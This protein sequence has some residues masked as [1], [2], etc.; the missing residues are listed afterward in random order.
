MEIGFQ[1]AIL[2]DQTL[3][4]VL[5]FAAQEGFDCIEAVCWPRQ[6][7]DQRRYAGVTHIDVSDFSDEDAREVNELCR[8]YGVALS[9]LGYYPNPLTPD[10][11]ERRVYV[12]HIGK[13]I[14]AAAKLGVEVVNTFVGRDPGRAVEEQWDDFEEV[15]KPLVEQAER[16]GVKIGIENCPMLFTLDE[17]PGGKNLA[18]S[19]SVWREMFERIPSPNFGLNFDPSHLIWQGIDI[20]RAIHEFGDRFVHIHAKDERVD[21]EK[22]HEVGIMGLGW[23]VPKIPGL[24][25]IDWDVFYRALKAVGWDGPVVIEVEDRAFED[26]LEGRHDA[27]RAAKE[28]LVNVDRRGMLSNS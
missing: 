27:L 23:H 4:E 16:E 3:E 6:A 2:P 13:V 25:D 14:S 10:P 20:E 1:T 18:I 22:L 8:K 7:T 26:S 17:W 12:E 24:G 5:A 21:R 19:P 11:E 28:Y 9:G 15:W